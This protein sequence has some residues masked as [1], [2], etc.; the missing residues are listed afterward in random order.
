MN[1]KKRLFITLSF[2]LI[3]AAISCKRDHIASQDA[4]ANSTWLGTF[5]VKNNGPDPLVIKF[6]ENKKATLFFGDLT[7]PAE[8]QCKGSYTFAND[9]LLFSVTDYY[10]EKMSF[11]GTLTNHSITGTWGHGDAD[12]GG[13]SFSITKQ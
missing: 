2:V 3:A 12:N 1:F 11:T 6:S 9:K 8:H 4:L 5:I 7:A 13:G 10:N